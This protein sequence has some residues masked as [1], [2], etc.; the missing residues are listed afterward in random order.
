MDFRSNG[1]VETGGADGCLKFQH[2][3]NGGLEDCLVNSGLTTLY[4]NNYCDRVSLADFLAIACEAIMGRTNDR[5]NPINH[6]EVGSVAKVFIENFKF[7]RISRDECPENEEGLMPNPENGCDGLK[8][9]F[10][11]N[12]FKT[13]FR[14]WKVWGAIAAI[15]GAHTLG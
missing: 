12:I 13:K 4:D 6:Y 7:G 15:S 2:D 10:A 5:H 11:E 1:G 14:K 9:I 8:E 3:E